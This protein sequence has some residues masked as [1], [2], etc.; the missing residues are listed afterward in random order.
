MW[1]FPVWKRTVV[2]SAGSLTHFLLGVVILW[3]LFAFA[4]LPDYDRADSAAPV[5]DLVLDHR[6]EP[7]PDRDR[8]SPWRLTLPLKV[9]GC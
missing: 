7:L 3:G 5:V 4:P 1:R 2:L 9:V 6:A 8:G